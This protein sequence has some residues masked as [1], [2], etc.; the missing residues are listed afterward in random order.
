MYLTL[1]IINPMSYLITL[2]ANQTNYSNSA[3]DDAVIDVES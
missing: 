1:R 2:W 3:A